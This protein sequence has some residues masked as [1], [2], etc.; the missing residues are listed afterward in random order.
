LPLFAV[1]GLALGAFAKIRNRGD[2]LLLRHRRSPP[3]P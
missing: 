1:C 2:E 3:M